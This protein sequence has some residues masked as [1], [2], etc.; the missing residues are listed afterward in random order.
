[1]SE[2]I[3]AAVGYHNYFRIGTAEAEQK[4]QECC[5]AGWIARAQ[6]WPSR[7]MP[8]GAVRVGQVRVHQG[9]PSYPLYVCPAAGG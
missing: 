6:I 1:V 8:E 5:P 3:K 2:E 9:D 4:V 7:R